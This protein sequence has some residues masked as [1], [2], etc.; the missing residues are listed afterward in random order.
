MMVFTCKWHKLYKSNY[1]VHNSY[2]LWN[3]TGF[4]LAFFFC[5]SHSTISF[6]L[7]ELLKCWTL[8]RAGIQGVY[9]NPGTSTKSGARWTGTVEIPPPDL[10]HTSKNLSM[11]VVLYHHA[12]IL[13]ICTVTNHTH[14]TTY[15]QSPSLYFHSPDEDRTGVKMLGQGFNN[16]WPAI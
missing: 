8:I 15:C 5:L 1:Y 11:A 12:C 2:G 6:I 16:H 14:F 3:S 10:L 7:G 4:V 9:W 13:Y